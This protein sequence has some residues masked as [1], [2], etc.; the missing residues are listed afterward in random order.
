M[1]KIWWNTKEDLLQWFIIVLITKLE[2][3][4]AAALTGTGLNYEKL[5]LLEDLHKPIIR[6]LKNVKYNLSLKTELAM[7]M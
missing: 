4:F 7:L 3:K 2:N 1:F 6:K 5:K